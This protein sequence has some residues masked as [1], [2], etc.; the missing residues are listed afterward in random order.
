M[1]NIKKNLKETE[2]LV[3]GDS[4]IK[5]TATHPPLREPDNDPAWPEELVRQFSDAQ[6]MLDQNMTPSII[7]TTCRTVLDIAT[8]KL[9]HALADKALQKR[10]DGLLH[11]GVITK[12]IADWGHAIRLDGNEAVHEGIGELEEAQQYVAFIKMFLNMTFA[13][14]RRIEARQNTKASK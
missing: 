11:A 9:D 2:G 10:I 7:I 14:P 13:L 4:L 3:G 5:V 1:E 6:R 8:K 12:P